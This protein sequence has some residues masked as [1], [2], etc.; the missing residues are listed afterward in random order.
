VQQLIADLEDHTPAA[1]GLSSLGPLV[2]AVCDRDDKSGHDT[3]RHTARRYGVEVLGTFSGH[4]R[5]FEVR[6]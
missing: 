4:N 2:Y 1:V 3:I 6:H 5:G